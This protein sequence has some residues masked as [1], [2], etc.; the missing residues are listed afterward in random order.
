M[1]MNE[2]KNITT[3]LAVLGAVIAKIREM[4][5]PPMQKMKLAELMEISPSAWSRVEKGETSLTA[6]QLRALSKIFSI[7]SDEIF[8]LVDEAEV[9]LRKKGV[10]IKS[11][12][13]VKQAAKSATT[14]GLSGTALAGLTA[15][16]MMPI[17]GTLLFGVVGGIVATGIVGYQKLKEQ[18]KK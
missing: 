9:G 10:D 12:D 18:E 15:S 8:K 11:S 5:V 13:F 16:G 17:F 4:Q 3:D 6:T 14:N 7:S 1:M 2:F